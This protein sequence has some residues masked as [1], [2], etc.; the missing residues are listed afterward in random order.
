MSKVKYY[1]DS[2]TLS[3]R[4][5]QSEKKSTLNLWTGFISTTIAGFAIL[6]IVSGAYQE[7]FGK[8]TDIEINDRIENLDKITSDLESLSRFIENQKTNLKEQ[9]K[10]LSELKNE[11][12]KLEK[13]V[14][15]NKENV[16][17]LFQIQE[18]NARK[19]IWTDR[20]I[21][22]LFGLAGSF[23]IAL[24][25]RFWDRNKKRELPDGDD[26]IYIKKPK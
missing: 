8:K 3:Y 23:L 2:E 17:A 24:L 12:K 21:G 6:I 20:I 25:F 16:D 15:M 1:Y 18:D 7:N 13:V 4:K 14:G 26:E 9:N 10:V 5:I 11:N 22:F 19:R